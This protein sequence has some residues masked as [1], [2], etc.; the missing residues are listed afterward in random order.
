MPFDYERKH[1]EDAEEPIETR[2][3][4]A[5]PGI[6]QC[7]IPLRTY[8]PG[9]CDLDGCPRRREHANEVRELLESL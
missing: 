3:N 7:T 2:L 5:C 4:G 1:T 8:R 9:M 6:A